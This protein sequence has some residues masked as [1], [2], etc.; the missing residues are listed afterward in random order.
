MRTPLSLV[1]PILL[2]TPICAQEAPVDD[3]L[4]SVPNGAGVCI[5]VGLSDPTIPAR[6]AESGTWI[7]HGLD[8]D[9]ANVRSARAKIDA[10]ERTG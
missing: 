10:S 6:V 1:V 8:A 5:V 9:T 3:F 7:V 2:L 4:R